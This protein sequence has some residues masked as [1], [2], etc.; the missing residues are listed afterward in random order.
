L[1]DEPLDRQ[2]PVVLRWRVT[3]RATARPHQSGKVVVVGHT[4]QFSGDVLDLGF[5]LGIDT[6]CFRGGWLTAVD[7]G[8]GQVWQ[9][10][11][12]GRRRDGPPPVSA[13]R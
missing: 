1:P 13:L 9:T 4:P 8:S 11:Q 3:D 10:D 7:V 12:C 2:P 6:N 5:L